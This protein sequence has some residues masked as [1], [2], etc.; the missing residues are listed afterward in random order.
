MKKW[1]NELYRDFSKEEVQMSKKHMKK[2]STSISMAIKEIHIN[3]ML[4][5]HLI[6]LRMATIKTQTRIV[7][8]DVGKRNPHTLLV[9]M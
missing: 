6:L 9:G 2:C 7:G 1:A 3:T 4:R 5:F 8:E